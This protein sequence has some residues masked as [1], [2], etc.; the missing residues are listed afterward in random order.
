MVRVRAATDWDHCAG[1]IYIRTYSAIS[2][3]ATH[4][5]IVYKLLPARPGVT[6]TAVTHTPAGLYIN[7]NTNP[8]FATITIAEYC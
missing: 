1:E 2:R 7:R 8:M 3:N 6:L 4:Y 5:T